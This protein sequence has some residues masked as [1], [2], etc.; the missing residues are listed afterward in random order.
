M[1][2]VLCK[3]FGPAE[4]LSLEEVDEP[5]IKPGHVIV[6]VHASAVNFPDVL[7]IEGNSSHGR[8]FGVDHVG[9]IQS[10]T[11]SRFDDGDVHGLV[12]EMLEGDRGH[13]LEE[14]RFDAE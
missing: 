8:H 9:G 10:T 11:Q 12:G 6:A 2:A 13:D 7:M 5:N 3:S 14:G 1:K 4:D